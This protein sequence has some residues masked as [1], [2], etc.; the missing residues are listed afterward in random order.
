MRLVHATLR[1]ARVIKVLEAGEIEVE[2][3]G[4]F[5]AKDIGKLPPVR[6]FFGGHANT[7]SAPL[8]GQEVWVMNQADNPQSL[9]W[10]RKDDYKEADK[11]LMTGKNVEILCNRE[12]GRGWA[13][14]YFEDGTGWIISNNEAKIQIRK[15]GSI[16]LDT[17]MPHRQ[18]DINGSNISLGT[19]GK[20]SHPAVYGDNLQDVLEYIQTALDTI[21]Q[22]ANTNVYT[23]P[24]AMALNTLPATIKKKIPSILSTNITLD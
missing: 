5:S 13:T 12:N 3:P 1:P 7:Y 11:D 21:K 9:F 19:E 15:N 22:A 24:I 17:G 14:I 2:A 16:F 4:L 6:P 10:F 20:S 23:K 8:V 18:I